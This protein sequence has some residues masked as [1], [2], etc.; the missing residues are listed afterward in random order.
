[1][2][3]VPC[4]KCGYSRSWH[5]KSGRKRCA[6]CRTTFTRHSD[7]F[8]KVRRYLAWL[9]EYFCLGVA[10]YR[11]RF[12]LPL[13]QDTVAKTFRFFRELIYDEAM[14]ELKRLALAGTIEMDEALFGGRRHGKRGWGA[15]GKHMVF[16]IYQRNGLVRTFP[17][18]SRE[19]PT[20]IP[21]IEQAT[22]PGSLYY[23]D[24]WQAYASLAM[25]GDHVV[26]SKEKGQPKGKD[27]A[28]GIEG[29]WSYAKHWLYQYRGVPKPYF[30]LYLKETE[31]RFN[32]RHENLIPSLIKLVKQ[33]L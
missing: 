27:H 7:R 24:D 5:L 11:L 4:P 6:R 29:F 33:H 26:V 23:T 8:R 19:A 18:S 3:R 9:I 12:L 1:M 13:D 25:R 17:V 2:A 31:W 22:K 32:H 10:V 20:L 30:P 14:E 16:G 15:E 28:N 21:L